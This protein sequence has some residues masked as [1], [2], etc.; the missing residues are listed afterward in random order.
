MREVISRRKQNSFG[1]LDLGKG[2][3]RASK[4]R[5]RCGEKGGT[6]WAGQVGASAKLEVRSGKQSLVYSEQQFPTQYDLRQISVT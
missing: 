1:G 6:G 5:D 2:I 3:Q 4:E